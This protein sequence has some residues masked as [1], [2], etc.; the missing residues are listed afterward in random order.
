MHDRFFKSRAKIQMIGGGFGNGKTAAACVKTLQIAKDYPGANI[1]MARSTYPKLNDTLRKEFFKWSPKDWIKSFNKTE[2]VVTLKNDTV[3]NFRYIAQQG[4]SESTTSNL[5]SATYDLVVVDQIEDPEITHKDFLDILGRMRGMAEYNGDDPTMPRTGPRWFIMLANP[6]RNWVYKKIVAPLHQFMNTGIRHPDLL[7]DEETLQP[8]IDLF[9]G[10]TY[11]N[12][13]N[14]EADFIKTLEAAYRGQMRDRFLLG[15]WA[16]YEGLV[17]PEYDS[18]VHMIDEKLIREFIEEREMLGYMMTPLE[19]YDHGIAVQ[20][21]YIAGLV[22]DEGNVFLVDGFYEAKQSI[23]TSAKLIKAKRKQWNIDPDSMIFADPDVFRKKA[24]DKRTVGRSVADMYQEEDILMQRGNND[25]TS[26][27]AKVSQYLRL[28]NFHKN[29]ITGAAPA[30]RLYISSALSFIDDEFND[31][32]WKKDSSDDETDK[33][34]DKK[35]H[36]MDTIKYMLS[37]RPDVATYKKKHVA[38]AGILRWGEYEDN[39][40]KRLARHR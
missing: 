11:E 25:I 10:S 40:T 29:P 31:Y 32:Y 5:L 37:R 34:V 35:D 21:C 22:D 28:F 30:P 26:G 13:H 39:T 24:G 4:N 6:T 3:I 17:Y 15:K 16:A 12:A 38:P 2:N 33:P 19:G 23:E 20:S 9:E 18:T 36:A 8:I 1:L 27:I 14:L 7:V